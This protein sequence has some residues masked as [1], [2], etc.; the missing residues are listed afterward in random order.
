MLLMCRCADVQLKQYQDQLADLSIAFCSSSILKSVFPGSQ[1]FTKTNRPQ[2]PVD[3]LLLST[4]SEDTTFVS[5]LRKEKRPEKLSQ[6]LSEKLSFLHIILSF[7][8]KSRQD[9]LPFA[10][11]EQTIHCYRHLPKEKEDNHEYDFCNL[12]FT[13]FYLSLNFVPRPGFYP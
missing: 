3:S 8:E 6:Q 4:L 1:G 9:H 11:P 2:S 13:L 10:R 7:S 12:G 5:I